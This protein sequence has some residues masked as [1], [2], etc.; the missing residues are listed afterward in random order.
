MF[1]YL[2]SNQDNRIQSSASCQLLNTGLEA[3][4]INSVRYLLL[5]PEYRSRRS[6]AKHWARH[7][8]RGPTLDLAVEV[9]AAPDIDPEAAKVTRSD[10]LP[11]GLRIVPLRAGVRNW[12]GCACVASS[13]NR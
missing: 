1:R 11:H 10:V 5:T 8:G 3:T 4:N 2:D 12:L 6:G 7:G 13:Q 9:A